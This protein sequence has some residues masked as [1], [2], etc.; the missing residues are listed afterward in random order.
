[1]WAVFELQWVRL[2]RNPFLVLSFLGLTFVFVFL[3]AGSQAD[4]K[5]TVH[6]FTDQL[7]EQ[8]MA[9]WLDLLNDSDTLTFQ[10]SD[11]EDVVDL[12][13]AGRISFG[14]H[15]DEEQFHYLV[16]HQ[17]HYQIAVDQHVQRVF[18]ETLRIRQVA[19]QT[20]I[21]DIQG[22]VEEALEQPLMSIDVDALKG[23]A[24]Q[25]DAERFHVVI[26]MTLYFAIYTIL[27]TISSIII[28]KR[29]GTWN[30]LILS[31]VK[32]TKIYLGHLFYCFLIGF[33]QIV[34]SFALFHY[35]LGY[36]FGDQFGAIVLVLI[37]YV[38]SI[39]ALG[40][41]LMGLIQSPQQLDAVN[42][43][44]ATGMAMLGGA[45]WPIDLISNQM[46]I[47][48]SRVMPI[49]HGM[50]GLKGAILFDQGITELLQPLSILL[51]MG[52]L[53]MGIGINLMERD[54]KI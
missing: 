12:I 30:R 27:N 51:L 9:E 40:M 44:V 26:G 1:M 54:T 16:G 6:T 2:K 3:L 18:Q 19:E 43:I 53:F 4:Q 31:P 25:A 29:D 34:V 49:F 48:L 21:T 36:D 10:Q 8:Q 41:F 32:K 35:L 22:R 13:E 5:M 11:R 45:F 24:S 20:G 14:L 38:F 42:P 15:V 39:V 33:L 47:A 50:E 17:S 52:V 46:M 37:V 7:S 23:D 28:Q